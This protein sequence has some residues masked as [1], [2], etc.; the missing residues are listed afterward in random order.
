MIELSCKLSADA[1]RALAQDVLD[2]GK[3]YAKFCEWIEAQGGDAAYAR[4]PSRF[5]E[6]AFSAELV[7]ESDGYIK[8]CNAAMVG[9][10]SSILGA[11]RQT[12]DDTIDHRAGI[13]LYKKPSD[14][15][16]TGEVIARLYTERQETLPE[17]LETVKSAL[18]FTAAPVESPELI[19]EIV[20]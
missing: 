19:Y 9:T 17:A 6:A 8:S 7:A 1:A 2:N 15:V 4:D 3:A 16:R 5:G 12:K 10:A 11:G 20:T 14:A 13:L 18:T